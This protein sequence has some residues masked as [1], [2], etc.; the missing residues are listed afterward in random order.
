MRKY[1]CP[2]ITNGKRD[3]LLIPESEFPTIHP[4]KDGVIWWHLAKPTKDIELFKLIIAF[5]ESLQIWQNAFTKVGADIKLCSTSDITKAKNNG[6]VFRFMRNGDA[7]LPYEF[8]QWTVAYAV[9]GGEIFC[10]DD[11]NWLEKNKRGYT[12]LQPMLVHEAGHEFRADHTNAPD[13]IMQ[14]YLDPEDKLYITEDTLNVIRIV[15]ADYIKKDDNN[16]FAEALLM[17][18]EKESYVSKKS[19]LAAFDKLGIDATNQ[20]R[21]Q[22]KKKLITYLQSK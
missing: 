21:K 12:K 14:P 13:D 20:K 22:L 10:N 1:K 18:L 15:Y 5:N 3:F 16:V 2:H 7:G 17:V 6:L 9:P 11:E 19:L 8:G 4:D